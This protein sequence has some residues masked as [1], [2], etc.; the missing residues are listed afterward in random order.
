MK[1]NSLQ[2]YLLVILFMI[3]GLLFTSLTFVSADANEERIIYLSATE[4]DYPPF[5]VTK[6]GEADGFSVELLKAVAQ[7]MGISVTFKIDQWTTLKEEL[8]N[9]ELDILP[10]VGYT[11]DRDEVYDFTVP[12]IVMRG[13]IFVRVGDES[14]QSQDDLFGKEILVLDGDNSQEWAIS[15]GLDSELTSTST[16]LEAFELLSEGQYDAVLAQ[17]LVGE[18]IISDNNFDNVNAV[19]TYDDDGITK[20][21][22]NLEGYEQKFCFAV[23]EGDSELLS[24]LNEGL[25]IVSQNGSYDELYQKW[26][27]FLVEKETLDPIDIL[28]Y[29]GLIIIPILIAFTIG[30]YVTTKR[31]IKIKTKQ[32]EDNNRRNEVIVKA[33]QKDFSTEIERFDY[34]LKEIVELSES[35]TGF[36]FS[37][38]SSYEVKIRSCYSS[39]LNCECDQISLRDMV[40]DNGFVQRLQNVNETI[41]LNDSTK[42]DD[43]SKRVICCDTVKKMLV[44]SI[45][46]ITQTH[47]V[48]LINKTMDY[49]ANN[50]NQISILLTGMWTMLERADQVNEIEFMGFHD[51]LTGL[52]NRRFLEEEIDRVNN[53]RNLPITLIMGD[54]NGL[55]LVNDAFGHIAGDELLQTIAKIIKKNVRGNDIASRWG[56]D[57]FVFLLPNSESSSAMTLIS[58]IEKDLKETAFQYGAASISFGFGT[59][60]N[61]LTPINEIFNEAEEMMYQNKLSIS[62]SVKGKTINTIIEKLFKKSETTKQHSQRVSDLVVDIGLKLDF[63]DSRIEDIKVL[64]M[65]HDIGK[66]TVDPN[67]L[68]KTGS[69]TLEERSIIEQHPLSGSKMLSSSQKYARFA[70]SILHHHE[71][72]DGKGYPNGLKDDEIPLESKILAIADAYDAMTTE[73]PYRLIALTTDEAIKEL[74]KHSGTQFD[75]NIVN[76]FIN[77]V[78]EEKM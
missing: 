64:G 9:G 72:I 60:K 3:I 40:K 10:L 22:L 59:K 24:I 38:S 36:M 34:V 23:V 77:T 53:M 78:L 68:N 74:V 44:V 47:V 55:K 6:N 19:Y 61:I 37:I 69:L 25:T 56:G 50:A 70:V 31:S 4:Y 1:E 7:E 57:E 17:G 73:R 21:K 32:I 52:Y 76:L 20:Y 54:V 63:S 46:G 2:K 49:S 51:S 33:F 30:Y 66:I 58:R 67:I 43:S 42:Q 35:K 12:Y 27:P 28:K 71:R 16:Y 14:I 15:I 13:N 29:V 65:I 41:I 11:E 45:K 18:K 75:T 62:E 8:K 5:S 39:I 48:V 26:F